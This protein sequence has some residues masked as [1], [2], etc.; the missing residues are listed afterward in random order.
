MPDDEYPFILTTGRVLEHWHGGTL[1][2]HSKLDELYRATPKN[3]NTL[4]PFYGPLLHDL[5]NP[6]SR[7]GF[8]LPE[9]QDTP[10][11]LT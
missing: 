10:W 8:S 6:M 3:T 1:A 4:F 5:K 7:L 11:R 2:R 9:H